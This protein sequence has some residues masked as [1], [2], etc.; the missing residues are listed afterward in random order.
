MEKYIDIQGYEGLYQVSDLGNVKSVQ[1]VILRSD[2]RRRT[3][4]EKIKQGTH[5]KGYK[6]I[7][8]IDKNGIAKSHYIHRLVMYNFVDKCDLIVDHING[9]KHDNRLVNL[10]YCTNSENLTYRNTSKK[11]STNHKYIYYTEN[12]FRVYK[13][14]KRFKTIEQALDARRKIHKNDFDTQ[15]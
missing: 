8:L 15:D 6:R 12:C 4:S 1:R 5:D 3:I 10:R 13:S 7:S 14:R 11:Y 2:N 9:I